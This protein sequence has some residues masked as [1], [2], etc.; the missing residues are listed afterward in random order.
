MFKLPISVPS[1]LLG[2]CIKAGFSSFKQYPFLTE[3]GLKETNLG[4]YYNGKWQATGS[5]HEFRSINPANE[6][7]IAHTHTASLKDYE[8]A[9]GLMGEA[10]KE[11][12]AVPMPVRGDIVRQIGDAFR[13]KKEPLG[14]LVSLEMGK[15]LS[16]GLGEVQETID[17]CDMA[18]GLSRTIG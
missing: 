14:R 4:A 12:S 5:T 11:W 2:R 7:L 16:E 17:I 15:I 18:C 9:I 3:L 10:Q 13:A 8:N 1:G 6:T